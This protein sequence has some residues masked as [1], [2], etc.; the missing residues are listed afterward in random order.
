MVNECTWYCE[1]CN[2]DFCEHCEDAVEAEEKFYCDGCANV[3]N[4]E[5]KD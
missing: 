3:L 1:H 4:L 2:K 5:K